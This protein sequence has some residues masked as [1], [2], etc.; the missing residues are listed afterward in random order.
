MNSK[1][2]LSL[3]SLWL[4]GISLAQ[5]PSTANPVPVCLLESPTSTILGWNSVPA[6]RV[7]IAISSLCPWNTFT[8]R[9]RESHGTAIANAGCAFLIGG[10]GWEVRQE[11]AWM[12]EEILHLI[13][14][15]SRLDLLQAV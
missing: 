2:R 1:S 6:T 3:T 5:S 7:T 10:Y 9:A 4:P 15:C 13:L 8:W 12:D 11:L 14:P